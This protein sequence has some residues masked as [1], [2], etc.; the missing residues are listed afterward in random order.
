MR[1]SFLD[2]LT[3]A[4]VVAELPHYQEA[5]DTDAKARRLADLFQANPDLPGVL[6]TRHGRVQSA[7]SRS[8]YFEV[9][10][11]YCGKDLYDGRPIQ[12]M[13]SRFEELGGALVVSGERSIREVVELGLKRSRELLYEPVVVHRDGGGMA[14]E[15]V[16]LVDFEDLLLADSRLS[17]LRQVQMGQILG[18]MGEGLLLIR[19]DR[20]VASEYSLAAERVLGTAEIAGR[21]LAE[22]LAGRVDAERVRLAAE[23]LEILFRGNVIENL[24]LGLNPLAKVELRVPGESRP[25]VVAF[26]FVRG[27]EAG[28]VR[29]VLV[30]F[31]DVTRQE[32]QARELARQRSET[33]LRLSLAV[34]LAEAEPEAVFSFL[35]RLEAPAGPLVSC[36]PG[37]ATAREVHALKG[38]AGVLGLAL[39]RAALHELEEQLAG[40][41][42]PRAAAL[43]RLH[44]LRAETRDLLT[45]FRRLGQARS[46]PADPLAQ[47]AQFVTGLAAELGKPARFV[48][49]VHSA[50]IPPG[51]LAGLRD[52]LVQL[53]RNA[54]VH[55]IE[56]AAERAARGKPPVGTLQLAQRHHPGRG[57]VE[58]IF[59]DDGAGLDLEA[60]QNHARRRGLATAGEAASQLIFEPG[61][62]TAHLVDE[63]AGRGQGLGVV[64]ARVEALGGRIAVHSERGRFCAFRLLLPHPVEVAV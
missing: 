22:L 18:A 52:A 40:S 5:V 49:R 37:A 62:S 25:R 21:T 33:E 63:H 16:V 57:V 6:L 4:S 53:A 34:A 31:E 42:G 10:G 9:V 55:G 61:V 58:L 19:E 3:T 45:R 38:E 43:G 50:E 64:K 36:E 26:R 30:R 46:A 32:E 24:V 11:G 12:L 17:Q 39:F 2:R 60:L 54:L 44:H 59:Q 35:E 14:E 41:E 8:Y 48:S 51:M 47:L 29:H 7:V 20:R 27:L 1:T 56:P 23:Y 15:S 28:T 13:M